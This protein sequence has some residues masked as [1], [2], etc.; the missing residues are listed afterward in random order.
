M[1]EVAE[2]M[3]G[4]RLV[5]IFTEIFIDKDAPYPGE[6]KITARQQAQQE[7][8]IKTIEGYKVRV[9]HNPGKSILK[10]WR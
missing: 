2:K 8:K 7:A 5:K 10:Y 3:I 6:S 4:D 1:S 9:L